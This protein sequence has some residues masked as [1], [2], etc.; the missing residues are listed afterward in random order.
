[1]DQRQWD[2]FFELLDKVAD[3]PGTWQ[4]KKAELKRQAEDAGSFNNLEEV[5]GWFNEEE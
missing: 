1:M 5:A 2:K 3:L 4:E